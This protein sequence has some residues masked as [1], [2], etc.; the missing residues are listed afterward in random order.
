MGSILGR[1]DPSG[2]HVGPRNFA[3]SD[4]SSTT[5]WFDIGVIHI[6]NMKLLLN[7]SK[8]NLHGIFVRPLIR[9]EHA[10]IWINLFHS[11]ITYIN[12]GYFVT[13]VGLP[14]HLFDCRGQH[15]LKIV[16]LD[17]DESLERSKVTH[18]IMY[19][20]KCGYGLENH[21][22]PKFSA[23]SGVCWIHLVRHYAVCISRHYTHA[24][25]KTEL[26]PLWT[27]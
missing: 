19:E 24:L 13:L 7:A 26:A 3:I 6:N 2:P 22:D 17:I 15:L 10:Y 27:D 12:A 4:Q 16:L 1:Q 21:L 23:V 25:G 8:N 9:I 18:V 5:H 11:I 20:S 14:I